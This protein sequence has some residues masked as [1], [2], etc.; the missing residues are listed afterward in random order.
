MHD[1]RILVQTRLQRLVDQFI[2][3]AQY[4]ATVPLTVA[5]NILDGEPVSYAEA[6][7]GEFVPFHVG[8]GWGRPW[9]TAWF[10]MDGVVPAEWDGQEIVALVDIGFLG[11]GPG[12]QCEGLVWEPDG[13]RCGI[14]PMRRAV[15]LPAAQPGAPI[16]LVI[17]A[18]ANMPI[19][20]PNP[21]PF[22]SRSTAGDAFF[23]RLNRA[24]LAVFNREVDALL[25]DIE[26]L[27]GTMRKLGDDDPRR[28][29]IL[30]ALERMADTI[31]MY[32]VVGTAAAARAALAPA[33]SVPA[34]ASAHNLVAVGHAHIDSAWLWPL[35]ETVRKCA[36]TFSSATELMDDYPDFVFA[37]SQAAQYDW[38]EQ[39]YP[40]I[41]ERITERVERGQWVPVGG[42]WVE[43]DM[44]LPSGESIARQL[45]FGQRYFESRFGQ[46]CEE[47]W[48]PDVFGYPGSLPQIFSQGGCDRFVTQKLSWNK[49]N[50]M[51]H[52]TFRWFGID[53][54]P[55][56]AHF[57]P[58][59]NYNAEIVPAEMVYAQSNFSDKAWSN[60]SI[61][62]FGFGDG[63]GGP[64]R[65]MMER[66]HR[67]ADLDGLPRL[68]VGTPD[69]FFDAVEAE[70]AE[71]DAPEW[72][73]ELYFEM[74]RGTFTSQLGTK[75]GNRT[76]ERLLR[77]A[78]LWWA[79]VGA[80]APTAAL[81]DIW[82]EV[83]LLQFHDIIPGS[84]IAWVYEDT[85]ES[86][87]RLVPQLEG[88]V[89]DALTRLATVQPTVA[90]AATQDRDEVVVVAAGDV[91]GVEGP[92]QVLADGRHAL[93]VAAPGLGLA[94]A[95]ATAVEREVVVDGTTMH[96]G[97]VS[98]TWDDSGAIVAARDLVR[99]RDLL[100]ADRHTAI[101]IA[102]DLPNEYD[103]WDLEHWARRASVEIDDVQSVEVVDAGPL[104]GRVRVT[105]V[106]GATTIVHD[107][108]VRAGS[109]RIDVEFD[110]DWQGNEQIMSFAVPVAIHSATA[111]CGIQ[112]GTVE[113]PRHANTSWD[114]AKFEVCA[115]RWVDVS[116][117]TFG[118]A[119]LDDGR[120]G[121]ALQGDTLRVSLF[122]AANWPAPGAD[123]GRHRTT[124]S[125][126][127]HDGDLAAVAREA[128]AL[129]TPL[130]I[131]TGSAPTVPEP[132]VRVGD[133]TVEV[134]ALK[135][136]DDGSGDLVVRVFERV[137]D[138]S[139][140][141]VAVAGAVRAERT[142]LLEDPG[143]A[144]DLTTFALAPYELAT[145]RIER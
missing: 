1:D 20:G 6:M 99:D 72:H 33:L 24:D 69:R 124:V 119:L 25:L 62:P 127:P 83:L 45:V 91:V 122:R 66:A 98:I 131:V 23:Y 85:D 52:H 10:R 113:R 42:M 145:L 37:C 32:D 56:V 51:P 44:N 132:L 7:A 112:F 58:V 82:K 102:P 31:D 28:Q 96:N 80:D 133:P 111:T 135:L 53:G 34:R 79:F 114:A 29:H 106:H 70:M 105:R 129:N 126:F 78:E 41:F 57:P 103:A 55:V 76:C 35:R 144:V 89:A 2:R 67:V 17:E 116:E 90:N 16:D 140:A 60:W 68:E 11:G 30:R 141:P 36:R 81:D 26:V 117:R 3:P 134:S 75:I 88:I 128:E 71:R 64:T 120:Y 43:A 61:V 27:T 8:S 21:T 46:R 63:G 74:H 4:G 95:T 136:A 84:S 115:H 12:F 77:E 87:G 48:I 104:L 138:R 123:R 97:L 86:Y 5:A 73:G 101:E 110:V 59:D 38:M 92:H 143:T 19:W 39:R 93:R 109:R 142:N 65:E 40:K 49:Q 137:G 118:V 130:R 121:H 54:T 108:V 47:V 100:L 125:L 14:H 9:G 139:V 107:Y 22:G 15:P 94:S 18:A 50:K 13:P